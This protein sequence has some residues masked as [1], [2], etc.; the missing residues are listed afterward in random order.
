MIHSETI[1]L[2]SRSR[3]HWVDITAQVAA[4][5]K[6]STIYNG[7]VTV[8]SLHTTASITI[9]ENGDP[10]V[11]LD[12]FRKLAGLVPHHEPFY[13]HAEGNSDS[14]VK[15]SLV[16]TDVTRS[17]TNGELILGVWQSIYF[18]EFDGPRTNRRFTVTVI[19][20]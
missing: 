2:N 16:G 5:I 9:N 8:T 19:G 7:I 3:C 13:C 6:K 17:I 14:H 12:F 4:V 15:T 1:S 20:E 18:C 10:D 11:E